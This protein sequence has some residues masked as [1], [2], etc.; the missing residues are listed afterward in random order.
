VNGLLE[1]NRDLILQVAQNAK[2]AGKSP[3]VV[4]C[5]AT[6]GRGI[7]P[8]ALLALK[9]G[10]HQFGYNSSVVA[11]PEHANLADYLT[12]AAQRQLTENDYGGRK[13][14]V[15]CRAYGKTKTDWWFYQKAEEDDVELF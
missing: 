14:F 5:A 7:D 6:W 3:V 2:S 9:S 10:A 1:V 13:F 15:I 4:V 8:A 12:E 11:A